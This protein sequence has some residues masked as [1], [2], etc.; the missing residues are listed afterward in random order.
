MIKVLARPA[1]QRT[2][3]SR[4]KAIYCNQIANIKLSGWKLKAISLKLGT[5]QGCPLSPYLF[6]IVL[7]IP[8]RAIRQKKEVNGIQIW[9]RRNQNI[10]TADDMTI[11]ICNPQN[12]TRELLQLIDDLS[13]T[14]RIYKINSNISVVILYINDKQAE[15]QIT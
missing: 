10:S 6:N 14:V 3:L 11:Y 9:K 12:S 13:K 5:R 7:Q 1:I 15:K 2:Y 4:A 8:A